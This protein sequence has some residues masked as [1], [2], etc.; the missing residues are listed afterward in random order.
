MGLKQKAK[1]VSSI[2]PVDFQAQKLANMMELTRAI[3]NLPLAS[4]RSFERR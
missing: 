4:L 1:A 2:F 3:R